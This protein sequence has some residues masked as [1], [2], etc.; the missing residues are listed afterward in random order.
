MGRNAQIKKIHDCLAQVHDRRPA[1]HRHNIFHE[2]VDDMRAASIEEY[3]R[4]FAF[5]DNPGTLHGIAGVRRDGGNFF[6]ANIFDDP[7]NVV[8]DLLACLRFAC[9]E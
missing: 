7:N 8:S 5:H 4:K 1:I 9:I 6:A 2:Q 3:F